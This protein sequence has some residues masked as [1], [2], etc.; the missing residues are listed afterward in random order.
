MNK[1]YFIKAVEK[2]PQETK[3]RIKKQ[4]QIA[5]N[6]SNAIKEKYPSQ[7]EFAQTINMKE[8]QL[9]RIISGT[10]NLTLSTISKLETALGIDLLIVP[11]NIKTQKTNKCDFILRGKSITI[12]FVNSPPFNEVLNTGMF[13]FNSKKSPPRNIGHA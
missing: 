13:P 10:E 8:S 3:K 5:I 2:V 11:E 4:M 9:S 7:K 1:N 12:Q 6:I